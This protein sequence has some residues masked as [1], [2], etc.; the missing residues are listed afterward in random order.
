MYICSVEILKQT[1]MNTLNDI[2]NNQINTMIHQLGGNQ[3][4]AMT[5]SKPQYKDLKND[6]LV[7][8]KLTRNSSKA[9]Y[10]KLSYIAAS[11]TYKMDFVS[12]RGMNEPKT[13][14]ELEGLHG[15][16]LQ[17]IFTDVTGLY[18]RL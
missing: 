8:F 13:V 16:D 7:A 3:F 12:M 6:P 14:Q 15:E 18:T 2:K 11:D 5:G 9:N 17:R 4:F 10:L 1:K